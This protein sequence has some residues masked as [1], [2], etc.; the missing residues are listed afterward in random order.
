MPHAILPAS[1]NALKVRAQLA[2]AMTHEGW[3]APSA[4]KAGLATLR[5]ALDHFYDHAYGRLDGAGGGAIAAKVLS[6]GVAIVL[7]ALF[8]SLAAEDPLGSR[9]VALCA[10]GGFGA[11]EMAPRSDVDILLVKP[12]EADETTDAFMQ[13][14]LY[15][16]WDL[17]IDVG[18]GAC[19][20]INETLALAREDA[21]ER[22][23]LL[24]LRHLA[25]DDTR[26]R[27]LAE[28]F[29]D[30]VVAGD[31]ASFVEAKLK[32]RDGRIDRA[33]RSRYM[34]EPH[35]K[36]GKGGLRDLQLMRW[37]AQFIYGAD[38]FEK[39]VSDRL[40]SV[41][42]VE[43][44]I[45]ADDFLWTVR[46]HIHALANAKD[47]RLT[48][49]LQPEI[50]RR[51][52][53][54]E[55]ENESAVERFMRR[56]FMT[57]MHVGALTRLVCAKLE[58]EGRKTKPRNLARFLP[59]GLAR[60]SEH[61]GEFIIRDGRLDFAS[62]TQIADDPVMLMKFFE[63]ASSRQFDLH[64]EAVARIGRTL[65]HVDE[66]FRRD[67]R[68]ARSFFSV[69]L[70]SPAPMAVL[71]MMTEAGLLSRY[72]PEFGD[73]VARTQFN[74]YHHFTVDEH[75][76]QAIGLLREI[77]QG[78]HPIDHPLASGLIGKINNR[79][80]LHLAVLLHDTGK[81]AGDQCVE[82][83]IRARAACERLG[84][85]PEEGELVAWLIESHLLMSDTAQRR[86]LG[87]PRTIA[88]FADAV[89]T[90]E[91]LRL[92]TILTIVD[93][94]SVGPGVWNGWKGQLLRDLYTAVK[95]VL[96]G[97]GASIDLARDNLRKKAELARDRVCG[98]L[99]RVDPA[100]A[101]WWRQQPDDTYW[102]S[103]TEE[104]RFRHAAFVRQAFERDRKTAVGIRVDRRRMASEVMIWTPDRDRF[105]TD[106]AAGFAL[107]G[108]DIVGAS[109]HTT[110]TGQ[111]FDIFYVQDAGGQPYGR[112][113]PVLRDELVGFLTRVAAGEEHVHYDDR[114]RPKRRDAAFEVTPHLMISNEITEHA[115]VIEASGRDRPGL[116][117]ELSEAIFR[118]ELALHFAQIDGYGERAT[119]VF[120]VTHKGDRLVNETLVETIR[121]E[122]MDILGADEARLQQQADERGYA[123]AP[124]SLLR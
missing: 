33:G 55:S 116:L 83:A 97:S 93:M 94:R 8:D 50:A 78:E 52:G 56:Y 23:S 68:A 15:A 20:S 61:A 85:D 108:A 47:E 66:D 80:A 73:I 88:D 92:L 30:E 25:G 19:R 117:A 53:F 36:S 34:V 3:S 114:A 12:E 118:H 71:R 5:G 43:N 32:E 41:E 90:V 9:G 29:R 124:A 51:M 42:D 1:L 101:D 40:L 96:R 109:I 106:I 99:Q 35:V 4:R 63:I 120:Y 28:R 119:D 110:T 75:T 81:G 115:T 45:A 65:F 38:A 46:F 57:A 105:F 7:K 48:F 31:E 27:V 13:Q 98:R 86:D 70:D 102:V 74:M 49:D 14:V 100:F 103:S 37:L 95:P 6:D 16:L 89:G 111:I 2:S 87:D 104:D 76:L 67:P 39:W 59:E 112:E 11:G 77:E 44:Y 91:R 121:A 64:P 62:P 60:A 113:D 22:T 107:R 58:S 18:G 26:S 54:H 10:Q 21:S 24:S 17:K 123:R 72:I 84:L 69:L 82:G 122:L 79:R